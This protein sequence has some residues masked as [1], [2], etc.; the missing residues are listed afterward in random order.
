MLCLKEAIDKLSMANHMCWSGLV[1]WEDDQILRAFQ[2]EVEDQRRNRRPNRATS[3]EC[4]S[5]C[6][7]RVYVQGE[8]VTH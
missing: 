5:V 7:S 4:M 8:F 2:Y 3:E 1:L 6:L